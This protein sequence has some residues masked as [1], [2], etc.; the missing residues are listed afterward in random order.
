MTMEATVTSIHTT[1][2]KW[3]GQRK[4]TTLTAAQGRSAAPT[5]NQGEVRDNQGKIHG[6]QREVHD[7]HIQPRRGL[8]YVAPHNQQTKTRLKLSKQYVKTERENPLGEPYQNQ[9]NQSEV[10][11][12]KIRLRRMRRECVWEWERGRL[13]FIV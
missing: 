6:S 3:R 9:E 13:L 1:T 12:A 10:A 8:Y 5:N 11:A 2:N 7:M 4:A